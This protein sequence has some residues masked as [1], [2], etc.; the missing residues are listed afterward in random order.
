MTIAVDLSKCRL[1]F[2]ASP[3]HPTF[4][5]IFI[6]AAPALASQP[7]SVDHADQQRA[8]PVLRIAESVFEDAHDIE[9]DIEANEVGERERAHR[10]GHAQF[11]DLVDGFRSRNA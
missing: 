9:A 11:E 7:A 1:R 8:G 4:L 5:L 3:E 10:M 2:E 6:K